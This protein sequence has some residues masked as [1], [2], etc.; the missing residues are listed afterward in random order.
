M[1]QKDDDMILYVYYKE[2]THKIGKNLVPIGVSNSAKQIYYYNR[3]NS[4]LYVT[5][6]GEERKK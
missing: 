1:V 4:G 2:E 3:K 6:L 5:S